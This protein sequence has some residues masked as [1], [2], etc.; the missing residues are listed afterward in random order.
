MAAMQ[1]KIDEEK[2]ALE[3]KKDM[4][5]EDRN[6][7]HRELQRR[8]SELHKAQDDQKILNE[9]LNA[10]QKKLIVGG[11]DLLAKSE[12]QEQLLEQSAL[13]MKERMA[14]Q[15]SMRKMMEEREQERMDI[16]EKYSSLQDEAHGKTKKLK[17]VWTMLMQA[18]SEVADM[19]AE[20][21]REMEALLE[22]V[23]ELS[24]E[25]R[26]SML[27]IDSFIPQEFQEMIEQKCVAIHREQPCASRPSSGQGQAWLT[28]RQ[29]YQR[30]L[31]YNLRKGRYEVPKPSQDIRKTKNQ[32]GED[33][34]W[35]K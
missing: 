21:Q 12:E 2:K 6:T 26:L 3:E 27:I 29:I 14:K 24:R 25:L 22:N 17:K 35:K 10:I 1:K 33:Q 28:V 20:H 19:Q 15:E 16:E 31:T 18:K 13:E 23:R 30:L 7:V 32:S 34:S 11:V 4:V 5:E 8:E 9:K